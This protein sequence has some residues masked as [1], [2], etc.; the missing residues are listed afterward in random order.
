MR[1]GLGRPPERCIDRQGQVDR[2]PERNMTNPQQGRWSAV[3]RLLQPHRAGI[4]GLALVSALGALAEAMFLVTVTHVALEF[5]S[6]SGNG[7]INAVGIHLSTR[8]ALAVGGGLIALRLAAALVGVA[9]ATG[10]TSAVITDLRQRLRHSY[11]KTAWSVQQKEPAGQLQQLLVTYTQE[12][13]N[14]VTAVTSALVAG[15]SLVALLGVAVTASPAASLMVLLVLLALGGVLNPLRRAVDQELNFAH[16]IADLSNV[17]LEI[18]AFGVRNRVINHLSGLIRDIRPVLRR[19][20]ALVQMN[21]PL[22]VSLAYV[23]IL[24]GMVFVTTLEIGDVSAISAVMLVTLRSLSYGQQFQLSATTIAERAPVLHSIDDTI[25]RYSESPHPIGGTPIEA[26]GPIKVADLCFSYDPHSPT[27]E[28]LSFEIDPGEIIGIIGPS[29]C[30]KTTLVHL[31]LG[32]REPSS[33][34]IEVGGHPLTT[35]DRRSWAELVGFVPQDTSLISGT[36]EENICFFRDID[37]TR[38]AR[39]VKAAHLEAE[40]TA[41]PEGLAT[42]LGGQDSQLSGGQRQRLA[43][44]RAL[45]T[46]PR[47]LVLDEPTASLDSGAELFIRGTLAELGR[48]VTVIVVAHRLS[49]LEECDRILVLDNGRLATFGR[50]EELAKDN[51]FY[52]SAL[53][54]SQLS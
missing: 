20:D 30:G 12:A 13:V 34:T 5:A 22:Y 37:E 9:L 29:G 18:E 14:S 49:T 16:E 47:L 6:S 36:I 48:K 41:M 7:T 1:A 27:L 19:V 28:H 33:G 32:L 4:A 26:I 42:R 35:I 15:L 40:I 25:A 54:H 10:I 51:S 52:Q 53:R 31:L 45:V 43:I 50:P 11:L 24:V 44:A 8:S 38:V 23:V 2:L 3:G 21:T 17:S 39:A 46:E